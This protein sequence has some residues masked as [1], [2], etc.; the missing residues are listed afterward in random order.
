MEHHIRADRAAESL[1]AA[2]DLEYI[3]M[4]DL[5]QLL[6]EQPTQ[7]TRL[8]LLV[9]LNRLLMS[10]PQAMRLSSDDCYMT[11]VREKRPNW[12]RKIEALHRD[13]VACFIALCELRDQ[14]ESKVNIIDISDEMDCQLREW[15][16]LYA[17]TRTRES[18]LL[19]EALTTDFGGEA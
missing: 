19:Q 5:R 2:C 6:I 12:H 3:I 11:E 4:G 18:Q 8:S 14:I 15:M 1:T 17:R 9:L 16:T 13:N 10:L 7:H